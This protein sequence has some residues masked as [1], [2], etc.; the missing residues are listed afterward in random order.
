VATLLI[1][2]QCRHHELARLLS[3]CLEPA[4]SNTKTLSHEI[5]LES[6]R[7]VANN[8]PAMTIESAVHG[9]IGAEKLVKNPLRL[10]SIDHALISDKLHPHHAK[11]ASYEIVQ[12]ASLPLQTPPPPP[13][14][15]T[16][17]SNIADSKLNAAIPNT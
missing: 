14:T 5:G 13:P 1:H 17:T 6:R 2:I 15:T 8:F 12:R 9:E 4:S 16:I 10:K 7:G 11:T 3:Q